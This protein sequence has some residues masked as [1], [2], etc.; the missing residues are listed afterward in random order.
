[1][2][3]PGC[4][5]PDDLDGGSIRPSLHAQVHQDDVRVQLAR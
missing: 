3:I 5:P 4:C 2:A 1:M